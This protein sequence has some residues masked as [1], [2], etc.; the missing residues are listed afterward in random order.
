MIATARKVGLSLIEKRLDG[1]LVVRMLLGCR[2]E[3]DAFRQRE[4]VPEFE[5]A[6]QRLLRVPDRRLGP[7][8]S[9]A[10]ISSVA[11]SSSAAGT[12]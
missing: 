9:L 12:T 1:L 7:R 4:I 5:P 6:V 2:L 10:T 3:C 11:S 8:R